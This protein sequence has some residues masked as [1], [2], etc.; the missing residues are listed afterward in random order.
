MILWMAI[1]PEL[2]MDPPQRLVMLPELVIVLLLVSR[3]WFVIY[4]MFMTGPLL[5]KVP[6]EKMVPLLTM[7][8]EL[9]NTPCLL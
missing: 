7:F 6:L 2:V 8:S 5:V 9:V 4:P 3:P 1:V